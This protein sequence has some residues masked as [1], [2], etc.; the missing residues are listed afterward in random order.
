MIQ[1]FYEI[2]HYYGNISPIR[3]LEFL[4]SLPFIQV[5]LSLGMLPK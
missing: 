5:L 3:W 1:F 2:D 4:P